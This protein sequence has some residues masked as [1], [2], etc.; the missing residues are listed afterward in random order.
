VLP[1]LYGIATNVL[2]NRRRADRR[3]AAALNRMPA[4]EQE[5]GFA[6]KADERLDDERQMKRALELLAQLPRREQDVLVLCVWFELSYE[7]ASFALGVPIGTVRSRLSR[8]RARVRE[9][10][11]SAGHEEGEKTTAEEALEP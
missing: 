6:E 2:R 9:L 7:D 4:P 11:L 8:A 5:R 1:W 10:D 3:F